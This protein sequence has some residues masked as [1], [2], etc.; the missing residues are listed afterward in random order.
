MQ[1][2]MKLIE[3]EVQGSPVQQRAS[4]GYI[5][6]TA[7]C[8][9][10]GK[11]WFDYRRQK[12]TE[13][14]LVALAAEA[15]IPAS[16]LVHSV[17]GGE[18]LLQGTW[19]HPQVAI[20]LAQ[21]LSPVFTVKVSQWVYDWIS[22]KVAEPAPSYHLR[23]YASN[24]GNVPYGHWSMLQEMMVRLIGPMEVRGYSLPENLLP[25]ISEGKM[26]CKFLRDNLNVDT[27]ALPKYVHEFEDGR[28]VKANAYPNALWP[29]FIEHFHAV[30]LPGKAENYFGQR[31]P[32]ALEYL[33][34][35]LPKP[36]AT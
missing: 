13:G 28:R 31:D 9:V 15:G 22:G 32:R 6:A 20:H 33:P 10:A 11:M 21:W 17:K 3:H 12:S 4:D 16:D 2:A 19:V 24:L 29:S 8:R 26:F 23:R 35:L 14:F 18:P 34:Y 7:M 1:Y 27:S 25:D 30:W 36:D 5:N